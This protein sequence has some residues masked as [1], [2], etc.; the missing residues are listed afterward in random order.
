MYSKS[1]KIEPFDGIIGDSLGKVLLP[2]AG[3]AESR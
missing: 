2:L 3:A 1:L